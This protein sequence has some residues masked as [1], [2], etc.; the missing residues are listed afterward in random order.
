M[1]HCVSTACDQRLL[2]VGFEWIALSERTL[3]TS[4]VYNTTSVLWLAVLKGLVI[5]RRLTDER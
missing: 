4:A 5:H 3:L 2:L 1:V